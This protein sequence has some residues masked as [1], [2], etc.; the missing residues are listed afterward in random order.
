MVPFSWLPGSTRISFIRTRVAAMSFLDTVVRAKGY[1]E[2]Q[3]QVSLRAL[4][5]EFHLDEEA[6]DALVEELV[7]VQRVAAIEGKVLSWI[8]TVGAGPAAAQFVTRASSKSAP[9]AVEE[10]LVQEAERRQLT[11]LFCD[12]V[13][14]TRLAAAMDAEDWRELLQAYQTAGASVAE[15]SGG[16]VAQYLGDGLLVYF[17]WPRA[18]PRG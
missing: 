18:H 15:R 16:H 7:D 6:L 1:L 5:R 2:G 9:G 11:E 3:G 8:G 17:G 10:P 4:R 12:L 13:D 14:S